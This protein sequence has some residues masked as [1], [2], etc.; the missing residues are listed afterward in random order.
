MAAFVMNGSRE[1]PQVATQP[2]FLNFTD[3]KEED[4]RL[5][6]EAESKAT[7]KS[8]LK[9]CMKIDQDEGPHTEILLDMH[10]H[11]YAFCKSK[12]FSAMQTSTLLSMMKYVLEESIRKRFVLDDAFSEFRDLL[13]KHSVEHPPVSVGI[14]SY[15]DLKAVSEYVH[16]TFFR[17]YKLYT[18]VY[19]THCDL[20]V[21]ADSIDH[22]MSMNPGRPLHLLLHHEVEER[23]QPELNF[24]RPPVDPEDEEKKA[25]E[26]LI[27][28]KVE[29]GMQKLTEFYKQKEKEQDE[30]FQAALEGK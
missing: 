13:L 5:M 7:V 17:H 26:E 21:T 1:L 12:N 28:S 4:L 8:L 2:L 30:W 9:G 24:L 18:Y 23:D 6:S 29:E 16:N 10:Y 19:M 15:D 11:N 14:F 27:K 20:K 22:G 25:K 3:V